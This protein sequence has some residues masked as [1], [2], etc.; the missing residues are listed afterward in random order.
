MWQSSANVDFI[1]S[2]MTENNAK[3]G[4]AIH[5][6]DNA[7]GTIINCIAY[8]NTITDGNGP[9]IRV[10]D[11]STANISYTDIEGG[12]GIGATDSSSST[13]NDNGNNIDSDPLLWVVL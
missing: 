11:N 12:I 8:G 1:N 13:I 7:V 5:I 4:G 6:D 2:T 3:S 9:Q 10:Y